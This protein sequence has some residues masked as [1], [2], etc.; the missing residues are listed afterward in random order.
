MWTA[1]THLWFGRFSAK[2][3]LV[4][5][6]VAGAACS[7][8]TQES[9]VWQNTNYAAGPIKKIAVFAGRVNA[10]DRRL[11]EDAFTSALA[12]HGVHATPSYAIFPEGNVPK[13]APEVRSVLQKDGYDG[14]LVSTMHDAREPVLVQPGAV[15]DWGAF[16]DAYWGPSWWGK[17]T[18]YTVDFV[19]FETTL[20][21]PQSGQMVWS[22]VTQTENPG[23][24]AHFAPSLT[25]TIVPSLAK[26]GLI[27]A[28]QGESVSM[29]P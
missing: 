15:Y 11:I 19:K 24:G 12:S 22:T 29:A 2:C 28:R 10:T 4:A 13:E 1:Q 23:S 9:S 7:T 27:P 25:N 5:L 16:Y 6:G 26:F 8:S 21:N 3:G 18:Y 14:A 17:P 20:W